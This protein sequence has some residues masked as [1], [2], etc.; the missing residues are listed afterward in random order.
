M[1]YKP[2]GEIQEETRE[3][4]FI[5]KLPD[6]IGAFKKSLPD[7]IDGQILTICRYEAADL[8]A[9]LEIIYTTETWDYILVRTMGM[10]SYRDPRFIYKDRTQ[11]EEKVSSYLES[12]LLEMEHPESVN[13]GEMVAE[14]GI[15]TWEYGNNLP[16]QIGPFELY[17][18]PAKAI[19][20][21]N[22][23]IILIDYTDFARKDQL[24]IM[25]NRLRDQFFGELKINSV[26]HATMDF[27]SYSLKE[28]Q[29]KLEEHLEQT[30]K[31][32]TEA[33][34]TI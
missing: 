7:T 11:F 4:E 24:I 21:L 2:I 33:D 17:L 23:S 12:V 8:R 13:L 6:T 32:V 29:K 20:H 34:H 25:Y 15:T 10:N 1:G 3:W 14:K 9:Q 26:F 19:E 16:K 18:T 30:L 5:K 31:E 27:D 22:G 28:L